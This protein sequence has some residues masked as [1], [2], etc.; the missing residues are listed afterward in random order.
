MTTVEYIMS[1]GA[2]RECAEELSERKRANPKLASAE[3]RDERGRKIVVK[4]CPPT[5]VEIDRVNEMIESGIGPYLVTDVEFLKDSEN[6]RQFQGR[7]EQGEYYRKEAEKRG[8]SVKGKKYLSQL[9]RFPGDPEAFVAG[10]GDVQKVLEDRG[11]GCEGAVKVK[12]RPSGEVPKPVDVAS[13]IVD[14]ETAKA[15]LPEMTKRERL[16]LREKVKNRLKGSKK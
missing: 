3:G 4:L 13:D 10:R 7:P 2:S 1:Q 9:A 6:G 12:A 14:R 5:Q 11:W 16:D 15:A 8:Q